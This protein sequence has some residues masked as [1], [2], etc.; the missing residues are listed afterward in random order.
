MKI[1]QENKCMKAVLYFLGGSKKRN[2]LQEITAAVNKCGTPSDEKQVSENLYALKDMG[3]TEVDETGA[4]LT[5][6]GSGVYRN[7]D[8]SPDIA[9]LWA[10]K[11]EEK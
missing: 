6:N 10:K 9:A 8:S 3:L 11:A 2:A 7:L 1:L 5:V 4:R